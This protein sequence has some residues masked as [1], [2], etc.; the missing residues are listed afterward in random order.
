MRLIISPVLALLV[1]ASACT[2]GADEDATTATPT[3]ASTPAPTTTPAATSTPTAPPTF[4]PVALPTIAQLSAPS[5]DVVWALV[6]GELLFVSTDRGTTWQHH[7][8]P[9]RAP[10]VIAFS[11]E[12]KGVALTYATSGPGCRTESFRL[13]RT[14]DR[15]ANWDQT[16]TA[17]IAA[18]E[19]SDLDLW[20]VDPS[21]GFLVVSR[22]GGGA[23]YRT[24]DVGATWRALA[25]P[26]GSAARSFG[27]VR[28]FGST[29][30]LS[31][32]EAGRTLVY[33][34]TDV[35]IAWTRL[36]GPVGEG[37]LALDT[38]TR[39]LLIG[40]PGMSQETTDAG[41]TWHPFTTD[42]SQAAP[43]PPQV[44]FADAEVGYATVRGSI[45]R[46]LDGGVH[47]ERIETPGTVR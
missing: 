45:Q 7:P 11:N 21:N 23:V 20:F 47:W 41:T 46:T 43:V 2:N 14:V 36:E 38:A 37:A 22:T 33:R 6:A 16:T 9:A 27:E 5:R 35:G 17:G 40:P 3:V 29:L 28:S 18:S 13:W 24:T 19:C 15:G 32:I 1:F 26:S 8:L 44:A 12:T 34:S 31:A 30:L 25:M 4:T 42:Y 10:T 39:W